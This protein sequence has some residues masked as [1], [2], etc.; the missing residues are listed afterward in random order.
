MLL[1]AR[2]EA[3]APFTPNY[4]EGRVPTYTLPDP[5]VFADGRAVKSAR[6]WRRRREELLEL[7]RR[8]VYGRSPGAPATFRARVTED[9]P[10]ALG[11]RAHRRQVTLHFTDDDFGPRLNLLLY[12]PA[13]ARGPVPVILGLNFAGNQTIHAD[14]AIHLPTNWVRTDERRGFIANR[15]TKQTRGVEATRWQV[16]KLLAR[17]FGL[18]TAYYGDLEPDHPEGWREGVRAV[19]PVDGRRR[20]RPAAVPVTEF[21]PDDWGAI[22]AW[23]WGLSR[24]MDF[25]EQEPLVDARRVALIGH[26][27]LG[28]TALWAGAEDE[29]FAIVISNE[30]GCGGAALSKRAF[31]E[32]VGRINTAF[33][34][35]FNAN[36]KR[37]NEREA[38]LPLDQHQ[39]IALSAPRPVYV[40]SA[41]EDRWADPRGE[42]LGAL[43]AEPVYRLLGRPGLGVA[44]MP[45][46]DRPVGDTVGYHVRRGPHDVLEYDWQQYLDFAGRHFGGSATGR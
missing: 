36:F 22:A 9:D 8:E 41:E 20:A 11:G 27:R 10:A 17:G 34:H 44:E 33:P 39:L 23:A 21:A 29:R 28:K 25:L 42:F 15:A 31:G 40:A 6:D 32:T 12:L 14:P 43:H 4:D 3:A 7:F 5:L 26:S 35:W 16:E 38:D 30:S 46:V 24:A 1:A 18:V 37:Y 2:L 19:F 45:P 13:A